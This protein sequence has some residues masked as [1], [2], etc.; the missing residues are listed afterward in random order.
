MTNPDYKDRAGFVNWLTRQRND[1]ESPATAFAPGIH[2]VLSALRAREAC[3]LARMSGSGAT[4]FGLFNRR[5]ARKPPRRKFPRIV[6]TGGSKP[7]LGR[8]RP[9]NH[10]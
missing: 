7:H 3:T 2:D 6:R 4:C 9:F 1:L 8:K 5:D 10:P